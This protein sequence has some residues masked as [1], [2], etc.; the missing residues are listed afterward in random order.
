MTRQSFDIVGEYQVL[1]SKEYDSQDTVNMYIVYEE[2]AKKPSSLQPLPGTLAIFNLSN[3]DTPLRENG[4]FK[5]ND[6]DFVYAVQGQSVYKFN[7][8]H[9]P[10]FLGHIETT[11]G[12]ISWANSPTE[13]ALVDGVNLYSYNTQTGV[14]QTVTAIQATGFPSSPQMIYYQD[15][16]FI[17]SF[18]QNPAYYY[19]GFAD[20]SM[21]ALE[22]WDANNFFIQQS[23]PD[24]SIGI[25]GINE[26]LFLFGSLSVEIWA[27]YTTANL[28]P[29]YRD[30]NF[31]YEFGCVAQGSIVKGVIDVEINKP[32]TSFVYW[33]STNTNGRGSFVISTGGTPIK[34][35][36]EAI[37]L[38]I[39]SFSRVSDCRSV[40]YKLKGHIFIENTFPTANETLVVDLTTGKWSRKVSLDNSQSPINSHV[41]YNGTHYVST[42]L[43]NTLYDLSGDYL[44]ENGEYIKR[45]RST[46]TFIEPSY[47]RITGNFFEV[48]F[49]TGN[50]A[51]EDAPV[52]YLSIS[53]DGGVT[54]GIPRPASM[55]AIG[56]YRHK[57]MW[58][59]L[60]VTY[61]F[62]F[63]VE[64][65]S[66]VRVYILGASL[67][68][69]VHDS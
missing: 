40:L 31:I 33:L 5:I 1:R 16:R 2:G 57:V 67:D 3:V 39:S 20:A 23:R 29:F 43:N 60:G 28:L 4:L 56:Q 52:A 6:N 42:S 63:K 27:P 66:P 7:E 41:Y 12:R 32:V 22:K 55:G 48:D 35:S 59:G 9:V 47:P 38:R 8:S 54:Y 46:H 17:L 26:R 44:T 50:Y 11:L 19:S 64:V 61:S 69:E 21:G 51:P 30:N 36:T 62:T 14:F 18:N 68:Y 65:Y 37:D 25:S 58:F 34:L 13:V 10:I 53:T 49:E 45:S 15:A 24:L